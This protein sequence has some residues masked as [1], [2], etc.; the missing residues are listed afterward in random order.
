M[1]RAAVMDRWG[2]QFNREGSVFPEFF[3][4]LKS[5]FTQVRS[6]IKIEDR[7]ILPDIRLEKGQ[8]VTNRCIQCFVVQISRVLMV[9]ASKRAGC[10][11]STALYVRL[12]ADAVPVAMA[13]GESPCLQEPI[14][15]IIPAYLYSRVTVSFT[16]A[17]GHHTNLGRRGI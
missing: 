7:H 9:Y 2:F 3:I 4:W 17:Y 10:T 13:N 8:C 14:A 1:H 15:F 12:R 16:H 5:Y 11:V 6:V